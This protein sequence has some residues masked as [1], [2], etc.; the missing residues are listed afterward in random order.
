LNNDGYP[1]VLVGVNG[2]PPL[3]LYNNAEIKNHWLGLNLVCTKANPAAIGTLLKW[4]VGGV[5]HQRFKSGGG[6]FMSSHDPREVLGIGQRTK[7]DWLEIKWP[8]PSSRVERFTGLPI[9]RY[10]T[11]VEG[12]G[13]RKYPQVRE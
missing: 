6:S 12:Q 5:Q 4:S 3:L 8:Q 10:I 9:D 13:I 11:I 7:I 1:D 2:G